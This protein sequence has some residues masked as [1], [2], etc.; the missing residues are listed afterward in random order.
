MAALARLGAHDLLYEDEH[1]HG[2]TDVAD[3]GQPRD[4]PEYGM[5][6]PSHHSGPSQPTSV[7][8]TISPAL[9]RLTMFS[10]MG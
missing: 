9:T 8:S 10:K 3:A 2:Q 4:H 1:A 7:Y 5:V 6:S